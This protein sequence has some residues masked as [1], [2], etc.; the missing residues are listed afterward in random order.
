MKLNNGG[1]GLV[2]GT[3]LGGKLSGIAVDAAADAYVI[4]SGAGVVT[5]PN[6]IASSGNVFIAEVNPV[7]VVVYATYLPGA[8]SNGGGSTYGNVGTIAV[9]GSGN[10]YVAGAAQAGL[11]VTASAFQTAYVASSYN[12]FF[13]KIDPALSGSA[14]LE[15]ATYLGGSHLDSVSGIALDGSGNVFVTGVTLSTNFPVTA[16]AFQTTFVGLRDAFV[17]KFNPS[18]A[19][20]QSLVYSTL[21]GGTVDISGRSACTGYVPDLAGT[22]A[23]TPQIDGG[24]AVDSA[25]NVVVASATTAVDFPTTPGAFQTQI[26][27]QF[28]GSGDPSPSDAFV[29]KLNATGTGLIY[30]TYLGGGVDLKSGAAGIALDASGDAYVTGWTD[31]NVFPTRNPIQA[32]NAGAFDAFVTELNPSGSGLLFSTYLGGSSSPFAGGPRDWGYGIATDSAGNAYVGGST[33]SS[34]FPTTPGAYQTTFNASIVYNGFAA[35]INIASPSFAVTGFP[36]PTTAGTA[37]TFTVT[38]LDA[39]GNTL[40]GYTGTVHF[41]SSDPQAVLPADYM[42]TAADQGV[43]TF[44][45]TL[46]TAGSQ[47]L[48]ASDAVMSGING[49]EGIVVNPAAATHLVLTGPSSVTAGT[50]FSFTVTAVDAYGNVATGYR[51]TLHF[52][53][54]DSRAALPSNHPFT[55]GDNGVHTFSRVKLRT[56]GL[57]TITAF[58]TALGSITGS[59]A[60]E[61]N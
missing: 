43:H 50:A 21:L 42:F 5:T 36:S 15:Y 44:G 40:T 17:A 4:G 9:D 51:G 52:T 56:T 12:A 27:V 61:V 33:I 34:N 19:G 3:N 46:K 22:I 11:P 26:N 31:S 30:S 41:T 57:Q 37:G 24:I 49:Q 16:G 2:Y 38:A 14:S 29:T 8:V 53:S 1:T 58:D 7:G 59:L 13:A 35:K 23:V 6:A 10:I 32:N 48:V 55:A 25:G 54:S 39:Q 60:I 18:L 28:T 20:T 45:A 47:A